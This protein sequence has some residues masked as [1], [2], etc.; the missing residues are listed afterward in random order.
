MALKTM[1]ALLAE[2]DAE[3]KELEEAHKIASRFTRPV[4]MVIG[5]MNKQPYIVL[6]PGDDMESV[7][8]YVIGVPKEPFAVTP[9]GQRSLTPIASLEPGQAFD[10]ECEGTPFID[11]EKFMHSRE[12]SLDIRWFT[13]LSDGRIARVS[14]DVV[15][16][17]HKCYVRGNSERNYRKEFPRLHEDKSI[18][19][20]G[21]DR[22]TMLATY[23]WTSME[24]FEA[25]REVLIKGYA[26]ASKA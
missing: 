6:V 8:D 10:Y 5:P 19:W 11:V 1:E 21:G 22:W 17:P 15:N 25:A 7:L 4:K 13:R 14:L 3:R 18:T 20:A 16:H 24:S 2:Q 9:K 12:T 26:D 23:I